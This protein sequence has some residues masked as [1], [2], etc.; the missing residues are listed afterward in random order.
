MSVE[1]KHGFYFDLQFVDVAELLGH[2]D[3]VDVETLQGTLSWL[4]C[5]T[6]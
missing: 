4:N 2:V 1:T 5:S 6:H 3:H